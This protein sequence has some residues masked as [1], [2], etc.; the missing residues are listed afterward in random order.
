M[1]AVEEGGTDRQT[2]S[3]SHEVS[4]CCLV[5][6]LCFYKRQASTSLLNHIY[7][8]QTLINLNVVYAV[9]LLKNLLCI[10]VTTD[11]KMV[12]THQKT[13]TIAGQQYQGITK[14]SVQS[15]YQFNV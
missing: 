10:Y 2:A 13:S 12:K 15:R 6:C 9:Q 5:F 11:L 4:H 14:L 3:S 8:Q 1:W 7:Q